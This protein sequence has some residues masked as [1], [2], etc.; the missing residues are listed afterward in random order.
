MQSREAKERSF[1][2][3]LP[4]AS[5]W[6]KKGAKVKIRQSPVPFAPPLGGIR[7]V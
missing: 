2:E 1:K 5:S 7:V 6:A 4:E 3:S